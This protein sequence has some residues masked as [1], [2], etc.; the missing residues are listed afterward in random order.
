MFNYAINQVTY[1]QMHVPADAVIGTADKG[2]RHVIDGWNAERT[3][4]ASEA[5]GDGYWFIE[6]AVSYANERHVFDRPI[7]MNQGV[8]FPIADAYMKVRAAEL[9]RDQAAT[10]FDA[11]HS[12][13]TEANMTKLLASEASWEAANVCLNTHG[14]YGFVDQYDVERKFRETRMFSVAPVNNNLVRSFIA[15]KVLGLPKSY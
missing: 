8:Q 13:G 2:F 7:G 12:T 1:R 5:I 15:T 3:L 11:G 14:G 6:R 4:L 9:M 10:V